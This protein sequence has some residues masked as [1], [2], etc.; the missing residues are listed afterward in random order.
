[1]QI[2]NQLQRKIKNGSGS[3]H[4]EGKQGIVKGILRPI[5]IREILSLQQK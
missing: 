3:I 5:S 1:M 2:L 4:E